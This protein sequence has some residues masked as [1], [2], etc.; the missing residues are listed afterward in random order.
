MIRMQIK[1]ILFIRRDN[2]GDLICTTPAIHAVRERFPD[3]R[4]GVLASTYNADAIIHNPD[5]DEVYIYEKAKHARNRNRLSVWWDNVKVFRKIRRE[6]YDVAIGCGTYS[7]RLARYTGLTGAKQRVGYVPRG[8]FKSRWYNAPVPEPD[9]P[10]HEVETV[11]YLLSAL[12]IHGP[13][14]PMRVFPV[15]GEVQK[16]RDFLTAVGV[17]R[18]KPLVAFH[19]SSRR[20]QNRWPIEKFIELARGILSRKEA[21]I[22]LLW[23]PG[24]E[25]DVHHPGDDEK[26]ELFMRS[27]QPGPA[28]YRTSTVR[29]LIAA[30]SV[31]DLIVCGDGGA[32]H[33]AAALGK[34]IVT[35]WGSS[36]PVRWRPWGV[37][38]LILQDKSWRAEN[39][40]VQSV[41][42]AVQRLLI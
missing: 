39:I 7:P 1:K 41:F 3:A 37:T 18:D 23:S 27:V 10:A 29:E 2:I 17:R 11:F 13:I 19:I 15:E 30:I 25:K 12:G 42:E 21:E 24:S 31:C 35:I 6:Q 4:I 34:R 14:P 40:S 26:A 9:Q 16:T 36:G 20:Q 22:M 32:M 8:A 5:I 28:A 38:H 33:I